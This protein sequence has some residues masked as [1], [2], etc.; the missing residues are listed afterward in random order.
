[1]RI[2]DLIL[3]LTFAPNPVASQESDR[4]HE[5]APLNLPTGEKGYARLS[6]TEGK[7]S[8]GERYSVEYTFYV[9]SGSYWVYNWSFNG[10]IPFPGQLAI[11]D[12][13]KKYIGDLLRFE[14]GS[15]RRPEDDDWLFLYGG[16]H[17]GTN[18]RFRAGYVPMTKHGSMSDLLP[19]GSYYIQLLLNK[20]F[21]S[22]NPSR[23]LG[24]KLD[25]YKTLDRSVIIR[26]NAIQIELVDK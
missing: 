10:L 2:V 16:S 18:L 26:S 3:M 9:T 13:E 20:A 23:M 6:S 5:E 15:Q 14:G 4:F 12:S 11:Y 7:L 17:V 19:A 25:F 8:R 24:D 1:M 21:L 22:P